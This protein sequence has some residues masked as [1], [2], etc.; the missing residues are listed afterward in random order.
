MCK[1]PFSYIIYTVKALFKEKTKRVWELDFL[2]G[3]AVILMMFDH[4]MVDAGYQLEGAVDLSAVKSPFI[5]ELISLADFY[6]GDFG[7]CRDVLHYVFVSVFL[8]LVGISCTFSRSNLRR[9]LEVGLCAYGFTAFSALF[10]DSFGDPL[11]GMDL[12]GQA[13]VSGILHVIFFSILIESTVRGLWDQNYFVLAVGAA[14]VILG[15]VL[16][17]GGKVDYVEWDALQI[18]KFFSVYPSIIFGKIG[19][20]ADYFPIIPY[21]GIVLIGSYIGKAFYCERK[22]IMPRLDGKWNKP[23]NFVGRHALWFYIGHQLVLFP[24]LVLICLASGGKLLF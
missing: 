9:A 22:S 19:A 15:L 8:L 2:R 7:Q 21:A 13:I 5:K 17:R 20:G 4:L 10:S 24:L 14:I 18:P 3:V 12:F 23:V 11:F 16:G 1:P 6:W